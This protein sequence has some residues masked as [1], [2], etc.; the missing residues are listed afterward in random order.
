MLCHAVGRHEARVPFHDRVDVELQLRVQVVRLTHVMRH[1][2]E[3]RQRRARHV[4]RAHEGAELLCRRHDAV[5]LDGK[6]VKRHVRAIDERRAL[7]NSRPIRR[8]RHGQRGEHEGAK[9]GACRLQ[10]AVKAAELGNEPRDGFLADE[11]NDDSG[12]SASD[13]KGGLAIDGWRCDGAAHEAEREGGGEREPLVA[14]RRR[15]AA[16]TCQL[17]FGLHALA[18]AAVRACRL[19]EQPNGS[20]HGGGA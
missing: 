17:E 12:A 8:R 15:D 1:V 14:H 2:R 20:G 10:R 6:I 4:V 19:L 3:R 11:F 5:V 9:E 16:V 18:R 7:G 13:G